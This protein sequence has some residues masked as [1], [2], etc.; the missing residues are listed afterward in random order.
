MKRGGTLERLSGPIDLGFFATLRDVNRRIR[1]ASVHGEL[2]IGNGK[3]EPAFFGGT[4][5]L[6]EHM[7]LWEAGELPFEPVQLT[8]LRQ[9]EAAGIDVVEF[10][11]SAAVN[12]RFAGLNLV[13]PVVISLNRLREAES[14]GR[15]QVE[16]PSL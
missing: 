6:L 4:A 13:R 10:P 11:S 15:L 3:C 16:W 5:R 1:T 2:T 14:A 9:L 12:N 8:R 7:R